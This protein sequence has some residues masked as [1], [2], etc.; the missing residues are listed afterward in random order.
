VS[1]YHN[2]V[3]AEIMEGVDGVFEFVVEKVNGGQ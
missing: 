3:I 1:V 2:I